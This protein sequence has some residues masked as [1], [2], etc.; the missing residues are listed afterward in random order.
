M[1]SAL[2]S[3]GVII[4]DDSTC[5]VQAL[6]HMM[7]FYEEE[8][9][10]QCTPCREGSGWVYKI[11]KDMISGRARPD[12]VDQLYDVAKKIEGRTICAF[13]EAISWPITSFIDAFREEFDYI[14]A[15]QGKSWVE[16]QVSGAHEKAFGWSIKDNR[17]AS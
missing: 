13:G 16:S 15:N 2:G 3:G 9:C 14:V 8:S 1:G 17:D 4:M 12:A 11:L 5:M 7:R 10:G 6:C